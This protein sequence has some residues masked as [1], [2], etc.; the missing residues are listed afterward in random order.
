M[1]QWTKQDAAIS[2]EVMLVLMDNLEHLYSVTPL[3]LDQRL[4]IIQ[5]V[6]FCV[7][8]FNASLHGFEVP[9]IVLTY[10]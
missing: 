10:L 6:C 9:K 8:S 4:E 7:Y 1:G 5:G 2:I 3:G